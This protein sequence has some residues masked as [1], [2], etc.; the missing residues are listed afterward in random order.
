[1]YMTVTLTIMTPRAP[2]GNEYFSLW[3][4]FAVPWWPLCRTNYYV[5]VTYIIFCHG[6][7][8]FQEIEIKQA[9]K[10]GNKQVTTLFSVLLCASY[11]LATFWS[12]L[13]IGE[14]NL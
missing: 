11:Q 13:T 4:A 9:A 10:T 14:K 7:A 3:Q 12:S 1:M 2:S 5:Y 8:V 6:I